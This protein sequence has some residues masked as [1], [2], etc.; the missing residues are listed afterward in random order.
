MCAC[1]RAAVVARAHGRECCRGERFNVWAL[2][3]WRFVSVRVLLRV[4]SCVR[5]VAVCACVRGRCACMCLPPCF[6]AIPACLLACVRACCG[7]ARACVLE[8]VCSQTKMEQLPY[9][10]LNPRDA[11]DSRV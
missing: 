5:G 6:W 4:R 2:A 7:A 10:Q 3:L 8:Y 11:F 1:W 9:P